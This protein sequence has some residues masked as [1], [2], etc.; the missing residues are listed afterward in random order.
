MQEITLE[1]AKKVNATEKRRRR[2]QKKR[3]ELAAAKAQQ[4]KDAASNSQEDDDVNKELARKRKKKKK[5]SQTNLEEIALMNKPLELAPEPMFFPL[6]SHFAGNVSLHLDLTAEKEFIRE[7]N[8]RSRMLTQTYEFDDKTTKEL[9]SKFK[10][11]VFHPSKQ[12]IATTVDKHN[13]IELTQAY[14]SYETY[15]QAKAYVAKATKSE[16]TVKMIRDFGKD[17]GRCFFVNLLEKLFLKLSTIQN[18]KVGMRRQIIDEVQESPASVSD[19]NG[20]S[21]QITILFSADSSDNFVDIQLTSDENSMTTYIDDPKSDS[22]STLRETAK[23]CI[24]TLSTAA[25]GTNTTTFSYASRYGFTFIQ[26]TPTD[27]T[28]TDNVQVTFDSISATSVSS[29]I[30]SSS[31]YSQDYITNET[32]S[33]DSSTTQ[34]T[35]SITDQTEFSN[36]YSPT[37]PIHWHLRE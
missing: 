7:H 35:T 6:F 3:T 12:L 10:S 15:N 9:K 28:T 30:K 19:G 20:D 18:Q 17:R 8:L 29:N 36:Q 32:T 16:T 37:D 27:I 5:V 31:V 25:D 11:V 4:T 34:I 33:T 24:S 2:K 22:N 14:T 13:L 1:E 21:T 26:P 23:E